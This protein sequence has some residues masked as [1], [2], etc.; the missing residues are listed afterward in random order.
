MCANDTRLALELALG[1]QKFCFHES[2]A[3][4]SAGVIL[5]IYSGLWASKNVHCIFGL[6]L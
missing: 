1:T 4:K 5:A 6:G 2:V 3:L